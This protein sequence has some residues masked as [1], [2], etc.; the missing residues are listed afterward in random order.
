MVKLIKIKRNL[1]IIKW[2]WKK[3]TELWIRNLIKKWK[4]GINSNW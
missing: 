1:I 2:K 4:F 3:N